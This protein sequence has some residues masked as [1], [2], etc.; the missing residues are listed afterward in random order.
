M[1]KGLP[2]IVKCKC[3]E[4]NKERVFRLCRILIRID[5]YICA[6]CG[7]WQDANSFFKAGGIDE[8]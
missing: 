3:K 5:G 1:S 2:L 4:C 8:S 6:K 7:Y